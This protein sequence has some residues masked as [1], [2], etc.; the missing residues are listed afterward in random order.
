M[1]FLK[2]IYDWV[3]SWANHPSGSKVLGIIS[4][5][6]ASFFPIPPDTLLI[7]LS[8]G[9]R[10]KALKFALI[11][12]ISSIFGA[13]LGYIVGNWLW[14]DDPA[15]YSLFANFFFDHIP[16][17][18]DEAFRKIK[19]LYDEYNFMIVFTAG[20]TPIPFKLFTISAGAFD[21]NFILFIFASAVSRSARFFLIAVLIRKYGDPIKNFI[22]KYFNL[23]AVGFTVLLFCGFAILK[24]II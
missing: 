9:K 14:W 20:F 5:C 10:K 16:G 12:S 8:L 19:T 15:K 13:C 11:C 23:L 24:L 18:T 4:F 21:I 17:F 1:N 2:K 3:L 6:E 22:D 7:P